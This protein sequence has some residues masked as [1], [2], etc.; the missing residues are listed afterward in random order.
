M[1]EGDVKGLLGAVEQQG[2]GFWDTVARSAL[3]V[4]P[5]VLPFLLYPIMTYFLK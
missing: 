1:T 5:H 3:Q 2:F 4:A